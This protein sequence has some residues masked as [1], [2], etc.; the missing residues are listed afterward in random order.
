MGK[1]KA[2]VPK[3]GD[4]RFNVKA[5]QAREAELQMKFGLKAPAHAEV[6]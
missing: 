4:A 1:A 3:G 2:V 6:C 5:M